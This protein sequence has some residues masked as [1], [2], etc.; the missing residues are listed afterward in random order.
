LAQVSVPS[1]AHP[2]SEKATIRAF[3]DMVTTASFMPSPPQ[4]YSSQHQQVLPQQPVIVAM[5]VPAEQFQQG[6][7]FQAPMESKTADMTWQPQMM[8]LGQYPQSAQPLLYEMSHMSQLQVPQLQYDAFKT[9]STDLSE[10]EE[11]EQG[12]QRLQLTTSA[13]RRLRRRRAAERAAYDQARAGPVTAG[14][15]GQSLSQR[16]VEALQLKLSEGSPEEVEEV[17]KALSGQVWNLAKDAAGCR[18]VQLALDSASQANA[19]ALAAELRGHVCEAATSPHAN[20]V[21]QKV[22]SQLTFSACS[23]LAEELLGTCS[24]MARH[25]YG[26][27]IL[28]RLMEFYS[29]RESTLQMVNEL[30]LEV[31]DLCCHNF[32]HHVIQSV[33]EHGEG[34]HRK[35][36]AKELCADPARYAKHRNASYLVEKALT[37]CCS[38]D[39]QAILRQLADPDIIADLA[40]TQFG[41]YVARA[42]LQHEQTNPRTVEASLAK[43]AQMEKL[44]ATRHGH[45]LL[46][47]L[48]LASSREVSEESEKSC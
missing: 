10:R 1:A 15:V 46:V 31:G 33:L 48:G 5:L 17:L 36:V 6:W 3:A 9:P 25:R 11:A 29:S 44:S 42:L 40:V 38:D 23:F 34:Q 27:R 26:C 41:G 24:K 35:L 28:C 43:L 45:R 16:S 19:A 18:L 4:M 2:F 22:V 12:E 7:Q 30:L 21:L 13:A 14:E 8:A 39:Q 32:G 20:Y 37:Y 47:D